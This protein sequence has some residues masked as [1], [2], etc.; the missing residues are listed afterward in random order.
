M[1][2]SYSADIPIKATG[3]A[4]C[5]NDKECVGGMCDECD[6]GIIDTTHIPHWKGVL[7]QQINLSAL[8]D[9]GEAGQAGVAGGMARA[10]KVLGALGVD[11]NNIKLENSNNNQAL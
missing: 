5:T 8:T 2:Q 1:V 3:I 11:V 7:V 4:W 10:E 9:I 6:Y